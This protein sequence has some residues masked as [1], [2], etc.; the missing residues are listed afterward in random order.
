MGAREEASQ[1]RDG[2]CSKCFLK[3]VM[4][5]MSLKGEVGAS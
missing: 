3:D 1:F 5:E 2:R 4:V